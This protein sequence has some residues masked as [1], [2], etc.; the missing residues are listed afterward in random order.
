MLVIPHTLGKVAIDIGRHKYLDDFVTHPRINRFNFRLPLECLSFKAPI[1]TQ[2]NSC[3]GAITH[4]NILPEG[5]ISAY[6]EE[7]DLTLLFK[8]N[9]DWE[10][11]PEIEILSL[12]GE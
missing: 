7:W 2:L 6:F 1:P 12:R 4:I 3:Y 8:F 10:I 9:E 5:S 11:L